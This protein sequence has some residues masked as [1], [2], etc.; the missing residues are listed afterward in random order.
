MVSWKVLDKAAGHGMATK[1]TAV[2]SALGCL[3]DNPGHLCQRSRC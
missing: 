2:A 1:S 3:H